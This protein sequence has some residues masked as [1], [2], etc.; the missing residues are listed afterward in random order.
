MKHPR[1]NYSTS[2]SNLMYVFLS[3]GKQGTIP[4]IVMYEEIDDNFYNVAFG[5]YD[6]ITKEIS[7]EVVSNNG[8]MVKI[9]ATVIG[10]MQ[11]FF[12]FYPNA[13]IMIQ[14][15]TPLR[16]R[17]YQRIIKNN[18]SEIATEFKV[19]A[20]LEEDSV[21]EY[22]NFDNQYQIFHLSKI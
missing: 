14:G 18:L 22:P 13:K 5:D 20:L 3:I 19:E 21:P 1:Y 15:S 6:P 11:D 8:D 12:A 7:D 10:T 9:L 16:T 4:K 17:L 2:A